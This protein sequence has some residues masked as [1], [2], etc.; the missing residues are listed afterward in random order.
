MRHSGALW[1][2]TLLNLSNLTRLSCRFILVTFLTLTLFACD[3]VDQLET[4]TVLNVAL[5]SFG[6]EL[7]DPSMDA[8]S[9]L[10]Y[11]GHMFDHLLGDNSEGHLGALDSWEVDSSAT[12]Y[13]L[14]LRQGM[15][16][17]D[18]VDVTSKDIAFMMTYY[19]RD[20]AQCG[21]CATVREVVSEVEIIDSQTAKIH[22]NNSDVIFMNNFNSVDGDMPI[23]PGLSLIHI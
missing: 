3:N 14:N 2:A 19:S 17:H 10:Q 8:K 18:G 1:I 20:S 4:K 16:W 12:T 9:G 21:G 11:H 6:P 23:L 5:P 7:L 13:T 15:K 22:L